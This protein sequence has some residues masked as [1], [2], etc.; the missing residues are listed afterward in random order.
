MDVR[1]LLTLGAIVLFG[2][3]C[4]TLSAEERAR[5]ARRN[6]LLWEAARECETALRPR[7]L[8]VDRVG[9]DGTLYYTLF[10]GYQ[11]EMPKFLAC[12]EERRTLKLGNLR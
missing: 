9:D 12:Y 4:S 7:R 5:I 2:T 11:E 1:R 6:A 10:Q 3:A 8:Q